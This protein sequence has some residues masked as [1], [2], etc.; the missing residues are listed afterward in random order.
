MVFPFVTISFIKI[1]VA[2]AYLHIYY[3]YLV[4]SYTEALKDIHNGLN[5][6]MRSRSLTTF[7]YPG[8]QEVIDDSH[9]HFI[10][11]SII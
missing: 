7:T 10:E 8:L 11:V 6:I 5:H 4:P 1:F 3:A 2:K 9:P